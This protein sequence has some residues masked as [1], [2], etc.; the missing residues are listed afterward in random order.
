MKI[1]VDEIPESGRRLHVHWSQDRLESMLPP[2]DPKGF[3][4]ERPLNADLEIHKRSDHIEITG[5][6][7]G[8]LTLVCD[9]CLDEYSS[10]LVRSVRIL[11]F[12]ESLGPR[13]EDVELAPD[14]LEY[15][16]FDGEIIEVE[17]MI[18]EE[19]FLEL[20]IRRLCSEECRGLCP[21]CG[22]NLNREPCLCQKSRVSSPFE[23]LR[24]LKLGNP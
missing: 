14:E 4:L 17:R 24:S 7:S 2:N 20:P 13:Q 9:R 22:A 8:Q 23:A 21:R 1:R 15:E 6:L 18:A 5:A 16:F 19:L 10:A 11:L 3:A 12:H